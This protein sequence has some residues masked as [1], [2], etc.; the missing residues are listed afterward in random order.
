[1]KREKRRDKKSR[2]INIR[3]HV[4]R[5]GYFDL[6]MHERVKPYRAVLTEEEIKSVTQYTAFLIR[7]ILSALRCTSTRDIGQKIIA[8][9]NKIGRLALAQEDLKEGAVGKSYHQIVSFLRGDCSQENI[10]RIIYE[11]SCLGQ[12]FV[13]D[14]QKINAISKLTKLT[15]GFC[16]HRFSKDLEYYIV[17]NREGDTASA[18]YGVKPPRQKRLEFMQSIPELSVA[19]KAAE[20]GK[21]HQEKD[22]P[23]HEPEVS[24]NQVV[25]WGPF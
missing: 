13:G 11:M 5:G 15:C 8:I 22:E 7:E 25:H 16:L 20:E 18:P 9:K 6:H 1:M 10:D 19:F 24:E 21:P 17:K 4:F 12:I 23:C 14:K 3:G 2:V